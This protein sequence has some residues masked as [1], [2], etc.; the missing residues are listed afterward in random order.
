MPRLLR[1]V[2]CVI[3]TFHKYSRE[4]G[5]KARLTCRELKRLLQG[6]FGDFLQPHVM[7]AVERNLNLLDSDRDG[8]ISFDEFVLAIFSLLNLCYVDIQSLLSAE[9][10]Q[11]SKS[12]KNPDEGLAD[13]PEPA[14]ARNPPETQKSTDTE[15]ESGTSVEQEPEKDAAGSLPETSEACGRPS[16]T[17][18]AP[19]QG[20]GRESKAPPAQ[21]GSRTVSEPPDV[22]AQGEGGHPTAGQKGRGRVAQA[23]VLEAHSQDGQ[24]QRRQ[25]P[26]RERDAETR[27]ETRFPGSEG[28]NRSRPETEKAPVPGEEAKG[29]EDGPAAKGTPGAPGGTRESA[30]PGRP[31]PP[32]AGPDG[33][34]E[35]RRAAGIGDKPVR[36]DPE[37]PPNAEGSRETPD[38]LAPQ[39]GNRSSERR[40]LRVRGR[41]PGH[42][43]PHRGSGPGA[44]G[45]NP[46]PQK[47]GPP[48][49]NGVREAA[50]LS[51]RGEDGQLPEEQG[52]PARGEHRSPGSGTKDPGVAV[53]R[54]GP[55]EAQ[56]TTAGGADREFQEADLTDPISVMQLPKNENS[57]KGVK[58]QDAKTKEEKSGAPEAHETRLKSQDE[59]D[60][61]SPETHLEAGEQAALEEEDGSPQKQEGEGDDQPSPAKTE[62]GFEERRQRD[63]EPY[64]VQRGAVQSSTLYHY[65]Q[66]N[67]WKQTNINQEENPNPAQA[68]RASGP[69]LCSNQSRSSLTSS[70]KSQ[71]S[72]RELLPAD[73]M[74]EVLGCTRGQLKVQLV[75]D[76]GIAGAKRLGAGA[77]RDN[78]PRKPLGLLVTFMYHCVRCD[79]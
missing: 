47:K 5:D 51:V 10:R 38:G 34:G 60:P 30:P 35:T 21:G 26:S 20:R 3:E 28:R 22:G 32:S 7:R 37:L 6:E 76:G 39:E 61:V 67:I 17:P 29:A 43:A 71:P 52:Q 8:T 75:S 11:V 50:V 77:G 53:E 79:V 31:E 2:L 41:S 12:E 64:S 14:A 59:D 36:E 78:Q 40:E 58:V 62:S 4:D 57:R 15:D 25:E 1:S 48:G 13:L 24:R 19:A 16:K 70:H 55:P 33:R 65:L 45:D 72:T 68:V 49:D 63:Q 46:D 42:V 56:E 23:P 73:N 69:E 9:P 74:T 66:E 54:Q 18:E 27:S 44:R